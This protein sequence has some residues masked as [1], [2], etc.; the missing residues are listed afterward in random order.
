VVAGWSWAALVVAYFASA[1]GLTRYRAAA[2]ASR[3]G[4]LVAKGGAR[5][6][7]Q[8]LANGGVFA[9]AALVSL[10]GP[11]VGWRALGVGALAAAASDTWATE[12][13]TLVARAPRS[14]VSWQRVPPGTSGG[15]SAA[16][17]AAAAAGAVFVALVAALVGWR[18]ITLAAVVGGVVGSTA[19]SLLGATV[20]ARR[21]C[22]RC[23]D[24]T[25]RRVHAC[26]T[27]TRITGGV[28]W[29]DNDAVNALST[30]AGGLIGLL[31]G[32]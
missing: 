24:V 8:V 12:V 30:A 4:A 13:G 26:G 23:D 5:D 3:V 32:R 27:P 20:Q 31:L 29:I 14:I 2:K 11:S 1:A 28:S 10:T 25:E 17:I 16:G 9:L 22:E 19:D 21:R 15:V 18:D 7:A 6:A